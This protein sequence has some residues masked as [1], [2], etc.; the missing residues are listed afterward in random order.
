MPSVMAQ[1]LVELAISVLSE[2]V[3]TYRSDKDTVTSDGPTEHTGDGTCD[4]SS[5]GHQMSVQLFY[6]ARHMFE[7]YASLVPTYHRQLITTLPQLAGK[8]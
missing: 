7:M 5:R 3:T 6:T 2:A 1:K 8:N 4:E